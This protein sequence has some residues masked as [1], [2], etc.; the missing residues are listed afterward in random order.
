MFKIHLTYS[1]GCFVA[2]SHKLLFFDPTI[3]AI[4][5]VNFVLIISLKT[6]GI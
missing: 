5:P 1:E 6:V 3:N 2:F 4:D